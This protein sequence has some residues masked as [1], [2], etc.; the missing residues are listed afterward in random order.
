MGYWRQDAAR[1]YVALLLLGL[2]SPSAPR[3]PCIQEDPYLKAPPSTS[4]KSVGIL[5]GPDVDSLIRNKF[6]LSSPSKSS[7]WI[8]CRSSFQQGISPPIIMLFFSTHLFVRTRASARLRCV[9]AL[10]QCYPKR[11]SPEKITPQDRKQG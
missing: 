6:K 3:T 7:C 9:D 11:S 2:L 10:P 5:A 1:W 8:E 4:S